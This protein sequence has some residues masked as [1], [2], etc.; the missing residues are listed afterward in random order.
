MWDAEVKMRDAFSKVR[1]EKIQA[2]KAR[3]ES[4]D[5]LTQELKDYQEQAVYYRSLAAES[6]AHALD[7][8]A[9]AARLNSVR[10]PSYMSFMWAV[11]LL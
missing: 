9:E 1:Y 10:S 8:R 2:A 6:R 11:N 4:T 7:C 3:A 5:E